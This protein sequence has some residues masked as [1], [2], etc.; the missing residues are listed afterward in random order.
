MS[1]TGPG[2]EASQAAATAPAQQPVA[3]RLVRAWQ[4]AQPV[5]G[6]AWLEGPVLA[7][8]LDRGP[9]TLIHLAD[10]QSSAC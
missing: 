10:P 7:L 2:D 4:E 8:V 3:V 9:R 1:G 6:L 5:A